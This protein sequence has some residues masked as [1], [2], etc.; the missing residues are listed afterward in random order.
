MNIPLQKE[1]LRKFLYPQFKCITNSGN[2]NTMYKLWKAFT[3]I[4]NLFVVLLFNKEITIVHIH[5]A[6]YS[7]FKRSSWFVRLGKVMNRKVILHI[8]GGGFKEY[9]QTNPEFISKILNSCDCVITLSPKWK[10][11]F[12]TI[13]SCP[14][15]EV[16][17]NIVPLSTNMDV[18]KNDGKVHFL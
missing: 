18:S 7:S 1:V 3:A 16:V 9:Y 8:H 4:I 2:G 5:T 17:N 14:M 13:T 12:K 11:Y 15:I 10:E 6:S